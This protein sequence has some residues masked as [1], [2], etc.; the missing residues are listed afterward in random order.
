MLR[1][2]GRWSR[3]YNVMRFVAFIRNVNLGQP[4]SPTRGQLEDAFL[5]AG[6]STAV[7][8]LSNGTLIFSI[9]DD[10]VPQR[11][12]NRACKSLQHVCGMN[13]PV[14]VCSLQHLKDLV[15]EDPFS[16]INHSDISGRAISFFDP[17]IETRPAAPIESKRKDC[18]IFRIGA[19]E[20]LSVIREVNGKTGYP[21][22]VLENILNSP[23]TTRNWTT[24]LRLINKHG[25]D[26]S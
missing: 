22:P 25:V 8:F 3:E 14:F 4:K 9:S 1:P 20:A 26:T 6:A 17:T 18:F 16:H 21:T 11:I 5:Q 2:S 12:A 10:H 19:G 15:A 13:Q 23:V 7:S 24:I